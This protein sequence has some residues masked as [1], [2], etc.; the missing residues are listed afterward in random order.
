MHKALLRCHSL[1][2]SWQTV[3]IYF[4]NN[5]INILNLIML[6]VIRSVL[7]IYLSVQDSHTKLPPDRGRPVPSLQHPARR[8]RAAS[9]RVR[10]PEV[11]AVLPTRH[12]RSQR[13]HQGRPLGLR[14][15][16]QLP[17]AEQ[18]PGTSRGHLLPRIPH[19]VKNQ[20]WLLLRVERS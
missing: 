8:Q 6:L 18:N 4:L 3:K 7:H 15:G 12:P 10:L 11:C 1:E 20:P 5:T 14:A 17:H 16:R 13:L 9:R 2:I 19:C